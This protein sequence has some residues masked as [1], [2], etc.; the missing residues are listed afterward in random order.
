MSRETETLPRAAAA[1]AAGLGPTLGWLGLALGALLLSSLFA[2]LLVAARVPALAAVLPHTD[3][4]RSAL[5]L[6]VNLSVLVWFMAFAGALW[7]LLA[8]GRWRG[9][10]WL[11]LAACAL[12]TPLMASTPFRSEAPAVLANYVPVIH[13]G[14]FLGGLGLLGFGVALAALRAAVVGRPRA[15]PADAGGLAALGVW[16][17]SLA[18][19]AALLAL[20]HS[21]WTLA[22]DGPEGLAGYYESL[23][24]GGGHVLQIVHGLLM[25][26]GWLWLLRSGPNL[27]PWA[28]LLCTLGLVA[29]AVPALAGLLAEWGLSDDPAARRHAFTLIMAIGGWLTL[30]PFALF[31]WRRSD[32]ARAEGLAVPLSVGLFLAGVLAASL[33]RGDSLLVPAHYHGAI[34]AVTL[35]YMGLLYRLLPALGLARVAAPSLRRQLAAYAL[36]MLI[37]VLG[38]GWSGLLGVV[39]KAPDTGLEGPAYAAM[40]LM[41]AG[42]AVALVSVLAFVFLCARAA[43]PQ[44]GWQPQPLRGL[45]W[46]ERS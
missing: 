23:F 43:L 39:R 17:A 3:F 12:G 14:G 21:A 42:A 22:A 6:H 37:L 36:G 20:A 45:R 4:F 46:G 40:T 9:P 34:G 1:P 11:A 44:R 38:L 18:A 29:A 10:G 33:I 32:G 15:L 41:G 19:L 26:S 24:W 28:R 16:L 5:V 27:G 31:V 7:S 2:A 25:V 30:V 8:P 35:V 13:E